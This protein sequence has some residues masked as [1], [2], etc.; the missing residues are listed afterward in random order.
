MEFFLENNLINK[1]KIQ[2]LNS[3]LKE[4]IKEVQMIA[5]KKRNQMRDS[6]L[7]TQEDVMTLKMLEK[8]VE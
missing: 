6:N 7:F 8:L 1:S 4:S 3:K 2:D 5:D